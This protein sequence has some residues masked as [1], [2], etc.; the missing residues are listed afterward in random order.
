MVS[1]IDPQAALTPLFPSDAQVIIVP[2]IGNPHSATSWAEGSSSWLRSLLPGVLAHP[3]V[4]EFRYSRGSGDNFSWDQ[5][6]HCGDSLLEVV[7]GEVSGSSGLP[8]PL[9]FVVAVLCSQFYRRTFEDII[10][11]LAG[12]VFLG[13][14]HPTFEN[15]QLWSK[16]PLLLRS[17]TR[18]PKSVIGSSIA[19]VST[20]ARICQSFDE[21]VPEVPVLSVYEGKATKLPSAFLN[22]KREILVDRE[23]CATQA[24]NEYLVK[25]DSSHNEI[26]KILPG[27]ELYQR[28]SAFLRIAQD[29]YLR[30]SAPSSRQG[31]PSLVA[32]TATASEAHEITC[33]PQEPENNN[34]STDAIAG[35][36]D[37]S[38]YEVVPLRNGSATC[39]TTL[40]LPIHFI[41]AHSPSPDFVGREDVLQQIRQ[42][43]HPPQ[44][45]DH[46]SRS[47][48]LRTFALCGIGG[49]GKTQVA[50]HYAFESRNVFDAIF[51]LNSSDA[52]KLSQAF[53]DISR[54]IGLTTDA[55]ATNQTVT[56]DLVL[57]WLSQPVHE[58][59]D[60]TQRAGSNGRAE[61]RWLLVFDNAD[62]LAILRDFWPVSGN[63]SILITSRDPLAKSRSHVS[64]S[65]GI[66]L[67]P[68]DTKTAGSL[69][70]RLT[71]RNQSKDLETSE[72]IARKLS[73]LPLAIN[74]ISGTIIRRDLSLAE[75]SELYEQEALRTDFHKVS[76]ETGPGV[77]TLWTVWAFEDIGA[78]ATALLGVIAFLDPDRISE[79]LLC[80]GQGV[81]ENLL[82]P[83]YPS[84]TQSF[85]DSRT[86][87]LT[88]S[89]IKRDK[90][91]QE[92]T[93]HRILQD[94]T[95][96]RL[97]ET[98]LQ[99]NFKAVV[100]LLHHSWPFGEFD[101]DMKRW[102]CY[103]KFQRVEGIQPKLARLLMDAGWY[104]FERSNIAEARLHFEACRKICN[105]A[106]ETTAI[107]RG[108]NEF[109][110]AEMSFVLHDAAMAIKHARSCIE[111]FENCDLRNEDQWRLLQAYNELCV[112][113][114]AAG[115]FENAILQADLAIATYAATSS[116]EYPEWPTINK[117][118]ALCNLGR[119]DEASQVLE[120]YLRYREAAF[121]NL[122]RESFKAGVA[123]HALG[124][125]RCAQG[126]FAEGLDIFFKALAQFHETVG[127]THFRVAGLYYSIAKAY[128]AIGQSEEACAMLKKSV[129]VYS[130]RPDLAARTAKAAFALAHLEL[131][132]G[133]VD[134]AT[135]ARSTGNMWLQKLCTNSGRVFN[136]SDLDSLVP[137]WHK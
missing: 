3:I 36:S 124:I 122:D 135:H 77:K 82:P 45:N 59:Y 25:S 32:W 23:F 61:P 37:V 12:I 57:G 71:S 108:D 91:R 63:G 39:K 34:D 6:V 130:K 67:E 20:I 136:E 92:I 49:V 80:C 60:S 58:L 19:L 38:G 8:R 125:T 109:C 106:P 69:I 97:N 126:Q 29:T 98:A 22:S 21:V 103:D 93:I 26:C 4:L 28:L 87:L 54:A 9:F 50:A 41:Q 47:A 53:S 62:N 16:L 83:H 79:E 137:H 127:A 95:C 33:P 89:L 66:D 113:Y 107:T 52:S 24:K 51:F 119:L 31:P 64:V 118:Q 115:Q 65:D 1:I 84:S 74:Q 75:F 78:T 44:P 2:D 86:E 123:L 100:E 76:L 121:G 112:A 55:N 73:G 70:R 94:A 101:Y 5:I 110:L 128:R 96:A 68:L 35:S 133:S 17:S 10:A 117:G 30:T 40:N 46:H 102:P 104:H 85:I 18:L 111:I 43:L 7:L 42:A 56:K 134:E 120:D 13:A 114:L 99:A 129:D 15:S 90:E 11:R 81:Q 88:S 27:T 132:L 105:I 131:A 14:P 116:S 48:G 72:D